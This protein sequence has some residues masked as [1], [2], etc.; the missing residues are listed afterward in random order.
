M[1]NLSVNEEFVDDGRGF[2]DVRDMAAM[3][4]RLEDRL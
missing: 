2:V 4:T 3:M 1:L